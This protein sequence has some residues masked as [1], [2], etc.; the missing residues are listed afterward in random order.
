[1]VLW[2]S[3]TITM[4]FNC[5]F[6]WFLVISMNVYRI[7]LIVFCFCSKLNGLV[8]ATQQAKLSEIDFNNLKLIQKEI[9]WI[10]ILGSTR[11]PKNIYRFGATISWPM[12]IGYWKSAYHFS[13]DYC[14]KSKYNALWRWFERWYTDGTLTWHQIWHRKL[15]RSIQTF[16]Q[17]N[18]HP[19]WWK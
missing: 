16:V 3:T 18:S 13:L 19:N 7:I 9:F 17:V 6:F 4:K 11:R 2:V 10:R 14:K 12:Y 1:M 8:S 5:F 15:P